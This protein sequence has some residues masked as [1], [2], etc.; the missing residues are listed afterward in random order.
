VILRT[1]KREFS[2]DRTLVM[3][4]LNVTP[5]SFSDG[6]K[7][8]T[9]DD[10]LRRVEQIIDDGADIIDIGGESS[11]PGST[12]IDPD[13]EIAR[14]TPVIEAVGKKFDIPISVDTYKSQVAKAALDAGAEIVNDISAFRFDHELPSVVSNR[15][16][17]V[18]IM[19][20]RGQF[21]TLHSTPAAEDIFADVGSDL[22]RAIEIAHKAG[23]ADEAIA[24]DVGIG[25]GKTLKQNLSLIAGIGRIRKEFARY[26]IVIG[27]SRKSFIGKLLNG[28]PADRRLE[29][30]L[31]TAVIAA[32]N[33]VNIV[34]AHDIKET[35]AALKLIDAI[36]KEL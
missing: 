31:A 23:I 9:I 5:D 25:F 28:A 15:R 16:C 34:R 36:C 35:S 29:G 11:R 18:I 22:R 4:I 32:Y 10:A 30:S 12:Q 1:S 17:A 6:G 2:L 27:T 7:V 26:P 14:I 20:S 19:H 33:G 3:G 13:E 21:E 24:I 8:L